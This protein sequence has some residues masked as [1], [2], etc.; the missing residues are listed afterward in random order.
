MKPLLVIMVIVNNIMNTDDEELFRPHFWIQG[1]WWFLLLFLF[2][3]GCFE[4]D[5][6][7]YG[8]NVGE[9]YGIENPEDCQTLCQNNN[10]CNFWTYSVTSGRVGGS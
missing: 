8:N 7:F 1:F 2:L 4:K 6:D 5:T 9:Q 3:D 10:E